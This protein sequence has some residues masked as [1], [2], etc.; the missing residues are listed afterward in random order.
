M[1]ARTHFLAALAATAMSVSAATATYETDFV[2]GVDGWRVVVDGVMGGRSTGRVQPG[3]RDTLLFTGNLSLENNG[4]FSQI[5]AN[6][7][8][9]SFEGADGIALRVRGDGRTYQF[10]IRVSNVRLMAGGFQANFTTTRDE[11]V[12]IE[13]PFSD[14]KLY[15]FGRRVRNAPALEPRLIESIGVTLG[16]KKPGP[17]SIEIDRIGSTGGV[18]LASAETTGNDL[19][20]VAS[21]AGLTTLLDLVTLAELELPAEGR[22]TIIAPTNDAFAKIPADQLEVLARPENRD[23]LRAIL[24]HHILPGALSSASLFDR[25]AVDTLGGQRV[26][27]DASSALSIGGGQVSIADV[28]F[29]RGVV[30]VVDSVLMPETRSIASI[31]SEDGRFGTLL[32]AVEAAGLTDQLGPENGDWTVL[33]PTDAAFAALPDG[34]VETLLRPENRDQLIEV[35]ALHVIPGRLYRKD[36]VTAGSARSYLAA[37]IEFSVRGGRIEANGATIVVA[38]VE[39]SNGVVH[40]ID[41]VILPAA[42]DEPMMERTITPATTI[43]L[44]ERAVDIGAPLFN[45]GNVE[46]CDAV[47]AMALESILTLAPNQIGRDVRMR[48]ETALAEARSEND[49]RERAWIYRRAMDDAYTTLVRRNETMGIARRN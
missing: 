28:A 44:L 20:S 42:K 15:S 1:P 46:A 32:A 5:R 35:L 12:D 40:A 33:A 19:V 16:D 30:H 14:F 23:T 36:L 8:S 22:F 31:A 10:D 18:M 26:A 49:A 11:W 21:G 3:L 37:P 39:A 6:V 34:T 25:V 47:Y 7:P 2:D 41:R 24:A 38:D 13:I 48:F 27:I 9:A 17:F 45:D 43:A 4:G 29:D